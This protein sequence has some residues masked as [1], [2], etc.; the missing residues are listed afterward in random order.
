MDESL[1]LEIRRKLFHLLILGYVALYLL[2]GR[3]AAAWTLGFWA[4]A[5]AF[6]EWLRLRSPRLNARI[7]K[8]FG[9]VARKEESGRLSGVVFTS[10]GC[11]LAVLFFGERPAVIVAALA[12]LA[13][14]DAAA[15]LVGKTMGRHWWPSAAGRRKSLEGSAACFAAC[16]CIIRAAGFT[17]AGALA[18]AAVCTLL[19]VLPLPLNDNLWMPLGTAAVLTAFG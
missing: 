11:W 16:L 17:P 14:G 12:C 15:A 13:F 4:L 9:A 1:V 5:V 8:L 19:E 2:L 10:W 6:I 3:S 18:A 7:F